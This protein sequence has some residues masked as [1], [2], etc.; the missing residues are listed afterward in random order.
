MT[1]QRGVP[2]PD[3]VDQL[4]VYDQPQ[5]AELWWLGVHGGASESSLAALV[6]G[7]PAASHGWPRPPRGAPANVVLTA[8]SSMYGLRSARSAATQWAAGMVPHVK[9]LGLVIVADAPGRLPRP[10]REF[11]QVISGGLPRTWTIPWIESWRVDEPLA[12][13]DAPREVRR[14]I[15]DLEALTHSGAVGTTNRKEHR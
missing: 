9:V 11:A 2:A 7:W 5:S 3:R 15:D 14:L 10:L 8:R 13:S 4:A 1:P 6:P 12:L